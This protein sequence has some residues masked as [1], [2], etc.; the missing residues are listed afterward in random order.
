MR[1]TLL[2]ITGSAV[3][4]AMS[5]AH[6]AEDTDQRIEQLQSEI[7]ELR[8]Q[9]AA[10]A[11]AVEANS[12]VP[13]RTTIGG[14]GELHYN[15]LETDDGSAQTKE[16]DLHRFVLFFGHAFDERTRFVS[17][18]EVEHSIAGEGQNGEVELE[19]AYVEFDLNPQT[20]A[21]GGVFLLPVGIL[22][23]THEPTTFY[24]VE[25]NPVEKNII[26]TTWWEG[27]AMLTGRLANSGF[28]YDAALHS[29]LQMPTTGASAFSIRSARQKVSEANANNLA[30]T[31]RLRYTGIRG[32][33]LAVSAQYQDDISQVS[34]DGADSA[35][36]LESHAIWNRGPFGVRALYARWDIDGDA[37]AAAQKDEQTGY[38]LEGSYLLNPKLG[39]FVRHDV[40]NTSS[41]DANEFT[42]DS[43][44]LNYWPQENV[45]LKFDYQNQDH[46][47]SSK[48]SDGFNLA[49][50]YQ[51]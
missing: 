19:Q 41:V 35:T 24:G 22:N 43:I 46:D 12:G 30:G 17:E 48:A 6:A 51:F 8:Q 37:I 11:D 39:A 1:N 29:G 32:L 10:T 4:L 45:V 7:V 16:M 25:R 20:A 36:L 40:W 21:R 2:G 9:V 42:Q 15:N 3:L 44:G 49:I 34:G 26:P 13:S 27:G 47:D 38:Y 28:S 33:E 14:Y 18:L 50:G 5:G 31:A 23:D